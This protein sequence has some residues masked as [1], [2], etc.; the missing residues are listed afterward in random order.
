MGGIE[1]ISMATAMEGTD[2][3]VRTRMWESGLLVAVSRIH[4]A[5]F[6][7]LVQYL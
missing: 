3:M 5:I 1:I 2:G 6:G 4:G 7:R